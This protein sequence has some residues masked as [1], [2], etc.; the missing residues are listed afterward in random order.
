MTGSMRYKEFCHAS[1]ALCRV[2]YG[3]VAFPQGTFPSKEHWNLSI[4][5]C[6]A[7]QE[8]SEDLAKLLRLEPE[9]EAPSRERP[10]GGS[11]FRCLSRE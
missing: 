8:P 2:L 6:A 9:E 11:D 1:H 7:V 4:L 5:S 3:Q 10:Q